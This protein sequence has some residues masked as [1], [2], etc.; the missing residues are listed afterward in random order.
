LGNAKLGKRVAVFSL[1]SGHACLFAKLCKAS[2]DRVTGKVSD[3][4]HSQFRCFATVP[5]TL[6]KNVRESRWHNWELL[7]A[8]RTMKNM[9]ALITCSIP[10][11]ATHIRFNA[12]GDFFSQNYFDAWLE[13]AKNDPSRIYYG[14]SKALPFW[15]KR[16]DKIPS[17]F[18]LVASMGGTHDYLIEKYNLRNARVVFSEGETK[19]LGLPIDHTDEH[20]WNYPGNFCVLIHGTQP[21]GSD[22][23]KAWYKIFKF[24]RGGYKSDYFANRKKQIGFFS[25]GS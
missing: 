25:Y 1:P 14:Y 24:G 20:V 18:H 2:A 8:A 10:S 21:K 16:L 11:S 12:S 23:G 3:G 7:K 5:E 6:F 19:L 17:N 13:V 4:P 15:V 22:A 9:V